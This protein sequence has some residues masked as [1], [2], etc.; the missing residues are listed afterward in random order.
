MIYTLSVFSSFRTLNNQRSRTGPLLCSR[1]SISYWR[2]P[3]S[4]TAVFRGAI[5]LVPDLSKITPLYEEWCLLGCYAVK[6]SNLTLHSIPTQPFPLRSNVTL[7]SVPSGGWLHSHLAVGNFRNLLWPKT[8]TP[9]ILNV[10]H[11]RQN[12]SDPIPAEAMIHLQRKMAA[13]ITNQ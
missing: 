1:Y 11:H 8:R 7:P 13:D 4:F 9:V 12:P 3:Q 10:I 5:R 6:T 2:I